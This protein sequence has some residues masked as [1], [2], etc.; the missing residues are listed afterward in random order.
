MS[1]D[2]LENVLAVNEQKTAKYQAYARAEQTWRN[3]SPMIP[4]E[5]RISFYT[6]QPWVRLACGVIEERITLDAVTA[7]GKDGT[8]DEK[9]T[10]Y[11]R[12]VLK[13]NGGDEFVSSV[14]IEALE[15][16]RSY[17]VPSSSERVDGYPVLQ[18]I[19]AADMVH[20]INPLTGEIAEA[21]QVYG[22]QREKRAYYTPGNAQY[23]KKVNGQWIAD[24]EPVTWPGMPVFDFLCRRKANDPFGRPEAKDIFKLQDAGTRVTSDLVWTSSSMAAPQRVI[25]GTTLEDFAPP[26]LD[27]ETGEPIQQEDDLTGEMVDV[28]DIA[29]APDPD[30]LYTSRMLLLGD[31]A[32]KIAEFQAANLQNFTTGMNMLTRNASALSGIPV[33]VFAVASDAN[34]ASGDSQREDNGRLITRSERLRQGFQPRW[35]A[36]FEYLAARAGFTVTVRLR[37]RDASLPNTAAAADA[38]VKLAPVQVDGKPLLTLNFLRR[39]LGLTQDD[40]DEMDDETELRGITGMVNDA[41]NEA[42]RNNPAA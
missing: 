9:A 38:A 36:L 1:R 26:K 11:L 10:A 30:A 17:V 4:P 27:P 13:A 8:E 35:I 12:G 25:S 20:A 16:G 24:R 37:W 40:I 41:V 5:H 7:F 28:P 23:L 14:H 2:T 29:N 21:L 6:P 32:A 22:A 18:M 3:T 42:Q 33:S 15:T 39:L 19:G 31:A 34:P